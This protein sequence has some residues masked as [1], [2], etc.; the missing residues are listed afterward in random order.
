MAILA[1][2]SKN[3]SLQSGQ[4]SRS[5]F[6]IVTVRVPTR[7]RKGFC[8]RRMLR[9]PQLGQRVRVD[10]FMSIVWLRPEYTAFLAQVPS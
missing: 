2:R 8:T 7:A 9:L 10:V 1:S 5:R 3:S 6:E 4:I